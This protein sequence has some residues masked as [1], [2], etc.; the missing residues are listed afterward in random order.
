MPRCGGVGNGDVYTDV[1]DGAGVFEP[2]PVR[3]ES[4]Q[5]L[6]SL[7]KCYFPVVR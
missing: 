6:A 1:E 7:T 5:V 3:L 2:L 4:L